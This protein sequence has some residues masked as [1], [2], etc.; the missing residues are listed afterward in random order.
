MALEKRVS[1]TGVIT[2]SL[3][4]EGILTG[5]KLN[6]GLL[7]IRVAGTLTHSWTETIE[8]GTSQASHEKV[9]RDNE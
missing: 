4:S 9:V 7:R 1:R 8:E 3:G 2:W 5:F 6:T